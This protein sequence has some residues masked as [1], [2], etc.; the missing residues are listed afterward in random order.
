MKEYIATLEKKYNISII[1][2]S[3]EKTYAIYR[4]NKFLTYSFSLQGI[5]QMAELGII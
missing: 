5:K 4:E 2:D 3:N 1:Y